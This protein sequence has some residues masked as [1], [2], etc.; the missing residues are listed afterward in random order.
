MKT[1][2][3]LTKTLHPG[4]TPVETGLW[5]ETTPWTPEEEAPTPHI[6]DD[7]PEADCLDQRRLPCR[8]N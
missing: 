7:V 1:F 8:A 2:G 5:D 4:E 6:P 3:D